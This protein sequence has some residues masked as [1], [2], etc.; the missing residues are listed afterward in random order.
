MEEETNELERLAMAEVAGD[1]PEEE[2]EVE[3]DGVEEEALAILEEPKA[4]DEEDEEETDAEEDEADEDEADEAENTPNVPE[5]ETFRGVSGEEDYDI[6]EDL[7]LSVKV[8]G[9]DKQV[10]IK[11]LMENY[12]GKVAYDQKF[13][14]LQIE[15][16]THKTSLDSFNA[17]A[18]NFD[19]LVKEGKAQ[20]ALDIV[21]E[22]AGLEKNTFV[23]AY[24][25]QLA[26][27]IAKFMD[28]TPQE[29]EQQQVQ[30]QTDYY[31]NQ[32]EKVQ[33]NHKVESMSRQMKADIEKTL[34]THSIDLERFELLQKELMQFSQEGK[35]AKEKITPKFVGEYHKMVVQDE[36]AREVLDSVKEGLST[37]KAAFDYLIALQQHNPDMKKEDLLSSAEKAFLDGVKEKVSKRV[38]KNS[39]ATKAKSLSKSKAKKSKKKSTVETALTFDQLSIE[40]LIKELE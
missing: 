20:E 17:N 31:K 36:L 35:L 23:N 25:S 6:P 37:D 1:F 32:L 2:V 3:D 11:E 40:D 9:E 10:N 16:E 29:R 28:M 38:R 18:K 21:L 22:S 26:P 24:I 15:R 12:S 19:N 33:E 4:E 14:E 27:T 30:Q 34:G 7:T 13:T 39:Q 8:D 5:S